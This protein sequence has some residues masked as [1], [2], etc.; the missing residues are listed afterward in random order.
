VHRRIVI[1]IADQRLEAT[2]THSPTAEA[3]WQLLPTEGQARASLGELSVPLGR[4]LPA[5]SDRRTELGI[6]E[7]AYRGEDAALVVFL[8]PTAA[9]RGR[10]PRAA[11]PVSPVGMLEQEPSALAKLAEGAVVRLSRSEEGSAP[12]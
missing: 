9:S 5:G 10:E 6:G 12:G 11:D 7:L 8:G 2:L 4:V 1:E 3:L